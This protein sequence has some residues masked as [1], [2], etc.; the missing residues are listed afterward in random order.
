MQTLLQEHKWTVQHPEELEKYRGKWIA[1]MDSSV[2]AVGG[3]YKEVFGKIKQ[4]IPQKYPLITYILK[5]E[6][7]NLVADV[8]G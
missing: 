8:M 5:R 2:I 6:E 7:E 4:F 3:S 1:V